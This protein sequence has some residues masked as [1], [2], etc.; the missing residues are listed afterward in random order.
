MFEIGID[1]VEHEKME[2]KISDEFIKRV[3][4]EKE[5]KYYY[6]IKSNKRKLEYISSRFAAKEAIF[7]AYKSG[8]GTTCYT[9]ISIL[10]NKDGSP[11]VLFENMNDEI[12][13]SISHTDNYS[14][15]NVIL[16][17]KNTSSEM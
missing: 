4:S 1:I 13:I 17:K 6:E 11:Y 9:N 5:L 2:K 15:A 7:K 14:V 16:I 3:L 12:K 10:N 8:D